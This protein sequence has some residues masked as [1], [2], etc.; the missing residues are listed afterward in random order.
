MASNQQ[1]NRPPSG[2]GSPQTAS[3]RTSGGGNWFRPSFDSKAQRAHSSHTSDSNSSSADGNDHEEHIK[4]W[5]QAGMIL[6]DGRRSRK[7]STAGNKTPELAPPRSRSQ[8][9]SRAS[10]SF[11]KSFSGDDRTSPESEA[12]SPQ[13]MR[14]T[15]S[16]AGESNPSA[17]GFDSVERDLEKLMGMNNKGSLGVQRATLDNKLSP[18]E[19]EIEKIMSK[20]GRGDISGQ[21]ASTAAR[22]E[23]VP[24]ISMTAA[25]SLENDLNKLMDLNNKGNLSSQRASVDSRHHDQFT[26]KT[27]DTTP[28]K[29][30]KQSVDSPTLNSRRTSTNVPMSPQEKAAAFESVDAELQKLLDMN[31]SPG[32]A[33]QRAAVSPIS[34]DQREIYKIMS[35]N[36]RGSM[37]SQKATGDTSTLSPQRESAALSPHRVSLVAEPIP[38]E[39][40]G[41]G[42]ALAVPQQPPA[43]F[44][45]SLETELNNLMDFSNRGS[46]TGQRATLEN[47]MTPQERDFQKLMDMNNKGSLTV[48]RAELDPSTIPRSAEREIEK[49]MEMNDKGSLV[50]QRASISP[51]SRTASPVTQS[52]V[53]SRTASPNPETLSPVSDLR[54]TILKDIHSLSNTP[55]QELSNP[56][57]PTQQRSLPREFNISPRSS[58]RT[59]PRSPFLLPGESRAEKIAQLVRHHKET[60]R[61]PI[62]GESVIPRRTTSYGFDLDKASLGAESAS[63]PNSEQA[64]PTNPESGM[65]LP[66]SGAEFFRDLPPPPPEIVPDVVK[67]GGLPP[68]LVMPAGSGQVEDQDVDYRTLE[69]ADVALRVFNLTLPGISKD[70]VCQIIGKGDDFHKEILNQYLELYEFYG[71]TLDGAFRHL[72]SHLH[73]NGETQQ[74]DRILY[75]F[76]RRFWDCNVDAQSTFRSIDIVYGILFSLVLLNTDLHIANVGPHN[77]RKMQR[78]T[79]VKNTSDLIDKMISDDET[80]REAISSLGSDGTKKWKKDIENMLKDLY[81]SVKDNRILQRPEGDPRDASYTNYSSSNTNS[82]LRR[83]NS[84]PKRGI[85]PSRSSFLPNSSSVV[86][87]GGGMVNS[88]SSMFRNPYSTMERKA[89]DIQ[90]ST[91]SLAKDSRYSL[92]SHGSLGSGQILSSNDNSMSSMSFPASD[93]AKTTPTSVGPTGS[94]ATAAGNVRRPSFSSESSGGYA[95]LGMSGAASTVFNGREGVTLEG[96]LIRKHLTDHNETR[97]RNRRWA[98][99]WCV[100]AID[101]DRGVELTMFKVDPGVGDGEINF[102]EREVY[103]Y[104][105]PLTGEEATGS[106]QDSERR[107]A[108]FSTK[109][110]LRISNQAPLVFNLLHSL[111]NP[112]KSPGYSPSRPYVFNLLLNNNSSHLFQCPTPEAIVEWTRTLNYWAARRSKEPLRGNISSTE[113]GWNFAAEEKRRKERLEKEGLQEGGGGGSSSHSL[114]DLGSNSQLDGSGTPSSGG[115]TRKMKIEDW[116]PPSGTGMVVSGLSEDLQLTS[117][118]RQ[119]DALSKEIEEHAE[120]KRPIEKKYA[121]HLSLKSKALAN[122]HK[123]QKYLTMEY[124]RYS[125]YVQVLRTS[126]TDKQKRS[127][128]EPG[129]ISQGA[130]SDGEGYSSKAVKVGSGGSGAGTMGRGTGGR[131]RKGRKSFSSTVDSIS[132]AEDGAGGP[133]GASVLDDVRE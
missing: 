16:T 6:M 110:L 79:F 11:R 27:I 76:S 121:F 129:E 46:L 103:D 30:S 109:K 89:S 22:E 28:I 35:L 96:L 57:S 33:G 54:S 125:T 17:S 68:P 51:R 85:K 20:I 95:G 91:D 78:K 130:A 31:N 104:G 34:S 81:T 44:S 1:P 131:R 70:K 112:L 15:G 94:P 106:S 38:E 65:G 119:V 116:V 69:P 48:Q 122:W 10:F 115:W 92:G 64:S 102:D 9:R 43:V 132:S 71:M 82:G 87:T 128:D 14:R 8:S 45:Q 24:A 4:L 23:P 90:S 25:D 3:P 40:E 42:K 105:K 99:V 107:S 12:I 117:M 61:D 111:A 19:R 114:N 98:K 53:L 66:P 50:V 123:K 127:M 47:T 88:P 84:N 120:F 37:T 2:S 60:S 21:R 97:A 77:G 49:M 39:K 93:S 72:C 73:L 101:D 63:Q 32:L 75:Q 62:T 18:E 118:R 56:S 100:M 36:S 108:E 67:E 7:S 86:S 80:V 133:G 126:A 58:I 29:L 26:P 5:P 41:K 124:D 113:Y 52:P 83:S 13:E 55:T 74:V 59:P